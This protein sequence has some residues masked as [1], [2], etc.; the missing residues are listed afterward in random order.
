[1]T[2]IPFM[3]RKTN[4]YVKGVEL[5]KKKIPSIYKYIQ[6]KFTQQLLLNFKITFNLLNKTHKD[7]EIDPNTS[8]YANVCL[9]TLIPTNTKLGQLQICIK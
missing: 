6:I 7:G 8:S 1:M 5:K 2:G 9:C 4:L 3:I